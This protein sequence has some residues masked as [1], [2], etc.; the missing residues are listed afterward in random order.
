[1]ADHWSAAECQQLSA[2]T[3]QTMTTGWRRVL[4]NQ[5]DPVTCSPKS[6]LYNK[7]MTRY[8]AVKA[9]N[10]NHKGAVA[11]VACDHPYVGY[12]APEE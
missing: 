7:A 6:P 8:L 12:V 9:Y 2:A 1:M 10:L 3:P 11:G 5:A 4:K